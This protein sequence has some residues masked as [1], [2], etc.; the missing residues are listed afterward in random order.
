M[1]CPISLGTRILG[2]A[3]LLLACFLVTGFL[4]PATWE[5]ERETHLDA[6]PE[7]VFRLLDAPEGWRAW[8]RWPDSGLVTDGPQRGAGARISWDDPDLGA[9]S[10]RIVEA[11]ANDFVR[12]TV[13]VQGGAMRTR[14][15][16]R[17][18][19]A[20]AGTRVAW[21]ETGDFGRNP[22]MGYWALFMERAQG[23]EMEKSL[24]RLAAAA[25]AAAPSR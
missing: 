22:L 24:E 25:T 10:F 5:V 4:L 17:L 21:H 14:G 11:A 2:G 8:T 13:E 18:S 23:R 20:G 15:T 16:V 3:A 7:A 9:G 12:Y 19:A 1:S 6:P